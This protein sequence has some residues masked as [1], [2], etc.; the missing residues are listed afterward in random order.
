M[1]IQANPLIAPETPIISEIYFDSFG[2]WTI[3]FNT[4]A[5]PFLD[6]NAISLETS[7]GTSAFKPGIVTN[8]SIVVIT[9][10]SLVTP[11]YINPAGDFIIINGISSGMGFDSE[12]YFYFGDYQ[13]SYVSAIN[14]SQS[15]VFTQSYY[16]FYYLVKQNSPDVGCTNYTYPA[17]GTFSGQIVGGDSLPIP[18]VKIKCLI[19]AYN[20]ETN[21]IYDASGYDVPLDYNYGISSDVN[22]FFTDNSLYG[23]DYLLTFYS[24][25]YNYLY[26]TTITV[27]IEP[28]SVNDFLF[29]LDCNVIFVDIHKKALPEVEL[30]NYPNPVKDYTTIS[31]RLDNTDLY[32]NAVIKIFNATGEII[33][34]L[35]VSLSGKDEMNVRCDFSDFP[36]G[37]YYYNLELDGKKAGTKQIVVVK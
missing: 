7:A 8:D 28:D 14:S 4:L 9:I 33:K 36:S 25:D 26:D 13:Y 31:C 10:D 12:F 32:K 20:Y 21:P 1:N 35:P 24:G 6:F 37:N 18:E 22:G 2:N 3:E 15:Y 23:R 27:S 29:V 5:F 34:I 11:L 19:T 17:T 30:E 16:G